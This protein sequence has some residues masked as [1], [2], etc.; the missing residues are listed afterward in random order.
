[1]RINSLLFY[2]AVIA[3]P[4]AGTCSAGMYSSVVVYGDSLSDNGNLFAAT[5]SP[6]SP[7]YNG[8]ASNGVVAVGYLAA[9]LNDTLLDFAWTGATTGIG[10]HL[11]PGGTPTSLG[12]H[13]L[14]GM[15]NSY[16]S[17]ASSI[18]AVA[19]TVLF[20]VWGGAND[21][22]SP[23]PLDITPMGVDNLAVADRAANNLV[24]LVNALTGLGAK[25]ILVP[26]LPGP[27]IDA[28]ISKSGA[29]S[30]GSGIRSDR[31]FQ[32]QGR[33]QPCV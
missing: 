21:F 7:Y 10:N 11:D 29:G 15:A 28:G 9:A 20:V 31:L 5:G 27:G 30:G 6:G 19:Q 12:I 18:A 32:F 1:M 13:A 16:A 25:H 23:S 2:C 26:G 22:L 33:Q 24:S 14:P 17:T 4:C 8:R 3:G